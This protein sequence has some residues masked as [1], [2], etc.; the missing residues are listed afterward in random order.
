MTNRIVLIGAGSAQFGLGTIGDIC[1]SDVLKGSTI[2]LHDINA[3]ALARVEN[4][5]R[6]YIEEH[7][8][9][10]TLCATTSRQEALEGARFCISSIEV[11][12]RFKLW[13]QDWHVPLQHGIRQVYGENGGPGGLF[14]SL[15]IIPPILAICEDVSR[16]CPDAH[17]FNFSNPMSRIC[18]TVHRK[19][20]DLKFT[21][22]CHEIGS[23]PHHLPRILDTPFENLSV[24]AG[25]L[26]H[27]SILLEVSYKGTGKDAYPDVRAKGPAY[28]ESLPDHYRPQEP[29]DAESQRTWLERGLFREILERFGYLPITTDSHFGEYVPWAYE[30]VDHRGILDFYSWYKRYCAEKQAVISDGPDMIERVIPIIEAIVSDAHMPEMAVNV[31]NMGLIDCLPDWIVVEAPAVIDANGVHG[32]QLENYPKGVGGLLQNQVAIHDLTAEAVLTGS[33][34]IVLQALLVDPI[35]W[36]V[37]AAEQ[38]L[39]VILDLQK[40]YLGYIK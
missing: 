21:G 30:V 34:E 2:V 36:S 1:K 20:P 19:Y 31:P 17:V 14:H 8:L 40:E 18:T 7:D 3:Q 22:L 16:I 23:L 5:G 29:S 15:R 24:T 12:D 11:G 6:Q 32:V 35:V 37:R 27:F 33:K 10:F 26:N 9:P 28:F 39:D 13:E 38:T 25:G 4:A